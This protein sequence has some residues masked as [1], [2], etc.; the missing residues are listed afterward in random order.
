M[1]REQEFHFVFEQ[2]VLK[3]EDAI[4]LPEG[5]RGIAR[6]RETNGEAADFWAKP[7]IDQLRKE[8]GTLPVRRIEDLAGDWPEEDPINEFLDN[9]ERGRR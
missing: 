5:A 9:L 7:S 6:I 4:D 3:P 8:Q 1:Y 2:G